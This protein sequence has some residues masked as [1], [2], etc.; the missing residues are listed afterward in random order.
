MK[1]AAVLTDLMAYS[2]IESAARASGVEV[3]RV[4]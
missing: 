3:A 1:V 2:R 4:D